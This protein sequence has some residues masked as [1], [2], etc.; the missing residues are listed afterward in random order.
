MILIKETAHASAGIQVLVAIG[1]I[2]LGI[3]A[4]LNIYPIVLSL[5]A[6][7]SI[8]AVTLLTGAVIGGRMV[9]TFR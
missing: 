6:M 2:V 5:V 7:L 9:R 4:L 3:L 8:G 1:S